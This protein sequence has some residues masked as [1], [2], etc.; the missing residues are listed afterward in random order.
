MDITVYLPDGIGERAK[1]EE[2]NLS[3]MLRESVVAE[4][5]RRDAM[6]D[7]LGSI[8]TYEVGPLDHEKGF[9]FTG[10]ITGKRISGD[11]EIGVYL[12]SDK[13]V[14]AVDVGT[15]TYQRLDEPPEKLVENLYAFFER[16]FGPEAVWETC[17]ALGL[18]PVIDL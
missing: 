1:N 9:A 2:L 12:T 7:A 18:P 4:L 10:R 5:A 15:S 14:L 16:R 6:N 3:R 8:E 13:R 17:E 11:E